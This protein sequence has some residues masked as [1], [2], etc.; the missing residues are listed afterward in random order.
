MSR[1]TD[2]CPRRYPKREPRPRFQCSTT[3]GPST[4]WASSFQCSASNVPHSSR[5]DLR[6]F[7]YEPLK[8]QNW[9]AAKHWRHCICRSN[10][11]KRNHAVYQSDVLRDFTLCM[12][13][14]TSYIGFL[15]AQKYVIAVLLG[16]WRGTQDSRQYDM[17]ILVVNNCSLW[18]STW[19][20]DKL[21]ACRVNVTCQGR[22]RSTYVNIKMPT[23]VSVASGFSP[24]NNVNRLCPPLRGLELPGCTDQAM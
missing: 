9:H 13:C 1:S 6:G 14:P 2:V 22:A 18:R 10:S 15:H 19:P 21:R 7:S 23:V 16:S 3:P 17:I 5:P 11:D 24:C 12:R 8:A 20:R 4:A